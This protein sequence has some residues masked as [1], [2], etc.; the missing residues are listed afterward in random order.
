MDSLTTH[1]C[2]GGQVQGFAAPTSLSFP[3]GA[4][5]LTPASAQ[6]DGHEHGKVDASQHGTNASTSGSRMACPTP[7]AIPAAG[8]VASGIVPTLQ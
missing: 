8:H 4:G 2:A 5:G 3:R 1:Q 7:A 6:K